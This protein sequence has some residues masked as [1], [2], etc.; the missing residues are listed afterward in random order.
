MRWYLRHHRRLPWRRPPGRRADPYTVVLSEAMLQQTQV[1]TVIEYYR[2][3]IRQFPDFQSLAAATPQQ[4]L[5]LWQGLGYYR[6]AQNLHR[7][8]CVVVEEH[9]GKLPRDPDAL[10]QLPGVGRYT[11]GAVASIAFGQRA[12]VVDGNVARVL[13]R[14]YV[15]DEPIDRA[16]VQRR[17]WDLAEALLP[18]RSRTYTPGDFN[19]ALM[20]LGA[21]VCKPRAPRCA[22]CPVRWYCDAGQSP[23]PERWPVKANRQRVQAVRWAVLGLK[24][25]G[26][27]LFRQRNGD[28]LWAG[29]FQLVTIEDAPAR[30][31][32]PH[33]CWEHL[34][35]QIDSTQRR[36]SYTHLTSH[37]RLAFDV[38]TADVRG[39][40][41]KRGAGTWR[42]LDDLDDLPLPRAQQRAVE[43]IVSHGG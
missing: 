11:A 16:E 37:R 41:T 22:A 24:R 38:Y 8:A 21:M 33:W 15:I 13:A 20:E 35:L 5:N 25:N 29:M 40:R 6:R 23:R 42:K 12:A 30:P 32:W 39:G 17:L 7:L 1:A 26:R 9:N 27:Y 14:W 43:L 36:E 18:V 34:G 3:F 19:Q 10:R 28:G 2:R 4:V 31:D